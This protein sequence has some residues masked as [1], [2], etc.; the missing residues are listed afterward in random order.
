MHYEGFCPS[1]QAERFRLTVHIVLISPGEYL[2]S[3]SPITTSEPANNGPSVRLVSPKGSCQMGN[4][5]KQYKAHRNV[6]D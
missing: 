4:R 6:R 1:T 3:S 5:S 2:V